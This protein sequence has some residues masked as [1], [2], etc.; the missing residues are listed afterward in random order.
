MEN[1]QE[2]RE[3]VV[4]N[5]SHKIVTRTWISVV[6]F[7]LFLF[8]IHIKPINLRAFHNLIENFNTTQYFLCFMFIDV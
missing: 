8:S 5:H 3:I 1:E 4:H 6:S 7:F 2:Y